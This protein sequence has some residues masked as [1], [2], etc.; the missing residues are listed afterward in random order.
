MK[1]TRLGDFEAFALAIFLV[2][3]LLSVTGCKPVN[4]ILIVIAICLVY[5]LG[6]L[7]EIKNKL[8]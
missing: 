8:K 5:I 1:P 6:T 4:L 3:T 2:V 7:I